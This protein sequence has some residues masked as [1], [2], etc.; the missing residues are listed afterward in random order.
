MSNDEIKSE[1]ISNNESEAIISPPGE[2]AVKIEVIAHGKVEDAE[3]LAQAVV[4]ALRG[5]APQVKLG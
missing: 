3:K 5:I 2:V 1:V 4:L